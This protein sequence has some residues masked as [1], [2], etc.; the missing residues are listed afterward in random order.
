MKAIDIFGETPRD[1]MDY[2][3]WLKRSD[4]AK[5]I[6]DYVNGEVEPKPI[7]NF[8]GKFSSLVASEVYAFCMG[9]TNLHRISHEFLSQPLKREWFDGGD[10]PNLFLGK[11][12]LDGDCP[13]TGIWNMDDEVFIGSLS[14]P[15]LDTLNDFLYLTR[16]IE[17]K[18]NP[19]FE[20]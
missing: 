1:M 16:H 9:L 6:V 20:F 4:Q 15:E 10:K 5:F 12:K 7:E 17:K 11:W 18:Y 19:E 2:I 14:D 3:G 8:N 13:Q